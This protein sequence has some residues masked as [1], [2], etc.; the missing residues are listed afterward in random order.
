MMMT[1][2]SMTREW[3]GLVV[4][5]VAAAAAGAGA[6]AVVVGAGFWLCAVGSATGVSMIA[7]LQVS[8]EM[9]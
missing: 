1:L 4:V 7:V 9:G 2:A 8:S 3:T 5:E 6:G